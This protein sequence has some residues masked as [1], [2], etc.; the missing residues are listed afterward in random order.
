VRLAL[1]AG[2]VTMVTS[3]TGD[4][5][6][7]SVALGLLAGDAVV[8]AAAVLAGLA[9]VGRWT[10]SSFG[11]LAGG[12]AVVGAAGWTG[13]WPSVLSSW[14]AALA[15]V[16]MCPR[17]REAAVAFGVVAA[18]LVAGPAVGG[19]LGNLAVRLVASAVAVVAA[20]LVARRVPRRLARPLALEMAALALLVVLA[21]QP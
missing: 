1:A 18:A 17:G 5:L 14:V 3:S 11:A 7:V 15:L 2:V 8:G 6:L 9:T 19:S 10:S 21:P 4:V 16:L 13:P 20:T 12:Q